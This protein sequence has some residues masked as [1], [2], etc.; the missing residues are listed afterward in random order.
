MLAVDEDARV[1]DAPLRVGSVHA[2]AFGTVEDPLFGEDGYAVADAVCAC[3][4]DDSGCVLGMLTQVGEECADRVSG[5]RALAVFSRRAHTGRVALRVLT[6]PE[7]SDEVSDRVFERVHR[8]VL[9]FEACFDGVESLCEV[10]VHGPIRFVEELFDV[11]FELVES[12]DVHRSLR[13]RSRRRGWDSYR[14][15]RVV[16]GAQLRVEHRVLSVARLVG[17][18]LGDEVEAGLDELDICLELLAHVRVRRPENTH[19]SSSSWRYLKD[20]HQ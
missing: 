15:D 6:V 19:T 1:F 14:A 16:D 12:F 11:C 2:F 7:V 13:T 10:E 4:C 9:R 5:S 3:V 18:L 17:E 20:A 8:L